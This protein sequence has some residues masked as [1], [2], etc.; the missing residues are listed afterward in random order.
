MPSSENKKR[1]YPLPSGKGTISA[2]NLEKAP[3]D[4]QIEVMRIW[5]FERFENPIECCPHESADGGYHYLWGGPFDAHDQL[6][7]FSG[8]VSDSTIQKLADEL[9][10]ISYEWSGRPSNSLDEEQKETGL[11]AENAEGEIGGSL[12]FDPTQVRVKIVPSTLDLLLARIKHGELDLAPGFQRMENIWT[13]ETQ[14]RLVESLLVKIPL[15]TFYIDAEDEEKWA[16]VDGLQR[17]NTFK[18]FILDE[19]FALRGLEFLTEFEGLKFAE[20]PRASQRRIQETQFTLHVIE[21]GTPPEVKFS[22][23]KR[24]NTGGLV[25]SAQEIRHALNQG[26]AALL[27]ERL[28]DSEYFL[29]ATNRSI[30]DKRMGDRE[31]VLRF[32]AFCLTSYKQYDS[33]SFD[34]FLSKTMLTMNKMSQPERDILE[35]RFARSMQAA[36]AVLGSTKAFRKPFSKGERKTPINKPLFEVWSVCLDNLSD[37]EIQLLTKQREDVYNRFEQ[38]VLKEPDFVK[39]ISLATGD[40]SKVKS[41]FQF[42]DDLIKCALTDYQRD[43]Q[44][45]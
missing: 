39:S 8:I 16:V 9:T 20:L 28:A 11:E 14:S 24:I 23:F 43:D 32:L 13:E 25:L 5:F 35:H 1:Q 42:I 21:S 44:N 45:N 22:I 37:S 10:A 15:P 12:P 31:C 6:L 18:R 40:I 17:L 41:R 36:E 3:A 38:L 7:E 33:K 34:A 26:P 19:A 30:S 29:S 27:L 2:A 4:E